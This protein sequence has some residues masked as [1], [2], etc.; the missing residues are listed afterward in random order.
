M[1]DRKCKALAL[2]LLQGNRSKTEDTISHEVD[3]ATKILRIKSGDAIIAT[4]TLA[5]PHN[6]IRYYTCNYKHPEVFSVILDK[7]RIPR[8]SK[9]VFK[10]YMFSTLIINVTHGCII[11]NELSLNLPISFNLCA[12]IMR[13][14]IDLYPEIRVQQV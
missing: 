13:D 14:C 2:V 12:A 11:S 3:A 1:E 4:G 6:Y 10:C 9:V 8:G 5:N 7:L